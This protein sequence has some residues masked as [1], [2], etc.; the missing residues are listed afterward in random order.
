MLAFHRAY[1]SPEAIVPQA[2]AQTSDSLLWLIPWFHHVILMEKAK[3]LDIRRAGVW[4]KSRGVMGTA[5]EWQQRECNMTKDI[6]T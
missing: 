5:G 1:P 6:T 2:A 4:Q 3:S